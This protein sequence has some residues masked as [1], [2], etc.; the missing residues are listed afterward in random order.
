MPHVSDEA[1][2]SPLTAGGLDGFDIG[3]LHFSE[4]LSYTA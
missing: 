1:F 4:H 3:N 2:P